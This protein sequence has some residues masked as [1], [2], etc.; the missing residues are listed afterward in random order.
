[1]TNIV[2][3]A[4][5][6]VVRIND[7]LV[8]NN[9]PPMAGMY[10]AAGEKY[11]VTWD[12]AVF[13]SLHE[14]NWFRFGGDVKASQNN[15]AGIGARGG[16]DPGESFLTPTLGIEAQIQNL[17]LRAGVNIPRDRIVS[18]YVLANYDFIKQRNTKTWASLTG[19]WAT[20]PKYWDKIRALIARFDAEVGVID[21]DVTWFEMHQSPVS[22]DPTIVAYAGSRA[23][24]K[25]S[26]K[27]KTV[28]IDFLHRY[29]GA[30]NLVVA[31]AGKP[32]PELDMGTAPP[33][34]APPA[35]TVP[36]MPRVDLPKESPNQGARAPGTAIRRIVLHNTAGGF[37]GAVSWLS[38][39]ASEVSAHLVISRTGK[40]AQLVP[41][42]RR[43]WHAGTA[44]G[45]SIGIE[46]EATAAA[47]GMTSI[48][49]DRLVE[50]VRY[51]MHRYS[52]PRSGIIPHRKVSS[53]SCPG[54]IWPTDAEFNKFVAENF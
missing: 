3:P 15:F 41:F 10:A 29:P 30:R 2:G 18:K 46:I 39:R 5:R 19:T 54:L 37:E 22:G 13:Q 43:A 47:K 6:S 33:P 1:M 25:L 51:L 16:G 4:T 49:R 27:D 11:G 12:I 26:T 17:A 9:C 38:N 36:S 14:T 52:I 7:Y 42:A 32:I 40:T 35:D 53:T 23:K 21:A 28:I 24:A 48:Q 44:N 20:D 45:D 8:K 31:A 50:W 34:P